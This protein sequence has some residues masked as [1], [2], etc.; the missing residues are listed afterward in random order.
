MNEWNSLFAATAGASATLTGLLF[1]GVSINL[2]KIL[3]VTYLPERALISMILLVN[4]LVVSVLALVP[5]QSFISLGSRILAIAIVV[6]ITVILIDIKNRKAIEERYRHHFIMNVILDQ[7][8]VIAYIVSGI[9]ILRN[10]EN[11][12]Y[13]LVPAI[14]FS[15]IKAVMD[16]WILLVEINR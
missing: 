5:N 14:I 7:L 16:A 2:A 3:S 9:A 13:W 8:A 4:I 11:G 10:H 1:V 15:F 6:W 12:L